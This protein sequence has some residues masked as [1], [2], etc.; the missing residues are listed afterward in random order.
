MNPSPFD[1]FT[2]DYYMMWFIKGNNTHYFI[3]SL[4]LPILSVLQNEY[5]KCELITILDSGSKL[6]YSQIWKSNG[7]HRYERLSGKFRRFLEEMGKQEK[8][9]L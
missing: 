7:K 9:D 8:Q 4:I 6:R 2:H 3:H 1:F 5:V